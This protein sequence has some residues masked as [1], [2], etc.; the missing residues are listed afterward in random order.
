MANRLT[1]LT[2]HIKLF[3]LSKTKILNLHFGT[4]SVLFSIPCLTNLQGISNNHKRHIVIQKAVKRVNKYIMLLIW[5]SCLN[6][7]LPVSTG[8]I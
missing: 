8:F 6:S 4:F 1:I 5:K 7:L 2:N 3:A